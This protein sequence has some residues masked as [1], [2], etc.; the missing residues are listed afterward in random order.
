MYF[1]VE[2]GFANRIYLLCIF[3]Y[4]FSSLGEF[5]TQTCFQGRMGDEQGTDQ[6]G[7][8]IMINPAEKNKDLAVARISHIEVS[9]A[10]Q[11]FRLG[12]YPIHFHLLGITTKS[13]VSGCGIHDTFNRAVNVHGTHGLVVE[14][15]VIYNIMGG[16]FFLEDGVETGNTFQ[17]N[18]AVKVIASTSLLNDDITP[19]AYWVTNPNN[20]VQHNTAAGGTHFG[21]WYRMH[22]HPDGPSF[23]PNVCPKHVPLGVFQNNTVHSQGWFGIWI[24]H[25][26][27]PRVDGSC[28]S[29]SAMTVAVFNTL[30]VWNCEK[31]AEFVNIGAA[32]MVGFVSVHN[33][34]AGYEGKTLVETPQFDET[35]GHAI[36]DSVIVGRSQYLDKQPDWS[37]TGCTVGGIVLPYG[38]GL[39]VS[40][41]SFYN[42][43]QN[44]CQAFTYTKI[45]GTC[46][47][48]CGGFTY[49]FKNIAYDAASSSHRVRFDWLH[50]GVM[51]DLDGTF[52]GQAAGSSIVPTMTHLPSR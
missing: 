1:K 25:D 11:A 18:L 26:Y 19:A 3:L 31:G 4:F 50:E 45:D 38:N 15:T 39:I 21:F 43:D 23:D 42:F 14:R 40:G 36:K 33:E 12:R 24:F 30:T 46:S 29:S 41:V 5:A 34:K 10:G 9:H 13:Y 49:H 20:T 22:D 52:S 44:S 37:G 6:F 47:L 2:M 51:V 7:G 27:F 48:Y 17:Y 8:H 35:N 28:S 16:A 32:Q